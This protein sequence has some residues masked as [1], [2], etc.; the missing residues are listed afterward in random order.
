MAPAD[1]SRKGT[2]LLLCCQWLSAY[3]TADQMEDRVNQHTVSH[4]L[5]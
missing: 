5:R 2:M 1:E 4:R 3:D